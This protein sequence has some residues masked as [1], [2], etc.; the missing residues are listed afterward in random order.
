LV[1][2]IGIQTVEAIPLGTRIVV[3]FLQTISV[4][5][6]GFAAVSVASL[7]PAVLYVLKFFKTTGPYFAL[8][9]VMFFTFMYVPR[10]RFWEV[11][12]RVTPRYIAPYPI[13]MTV[14]S[15][16]VYEDRAIG[17]FDSESDSSDDESVE[18]EFAEQARRVPR[19]QRQR[20]WGKY[21]AFH[22]RR[23]LAF[24]RYCSSHQ[25]PY[26]LTP[27]RLLDIWW[28]VFALF[29]ITLIDRHSI[30]DPNQP[31]FNIFTVSEYGGCFYL[32]PDPLIA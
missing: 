1:L 19:H 13:A 6:A 21:L 5:C 23:Q 27:S 10:C 20:V 25:Y 8:F 22:A 12:Q 29:L 17:V 26:S 15:T 31:L 16:N 24:G 18:K 30:I 7:A 32:S 14:R 28:L 11:A 4:R 2:D 9:R 3:G